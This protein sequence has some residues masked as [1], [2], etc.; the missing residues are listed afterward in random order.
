MQTDFD[1]MLGEDFLA[2]LFKLVAGPRCEEDRASFARKRQRGGAADAF[3]SA[4]YQR[5]FPG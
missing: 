1:F 2:Q 4:C 3:R 5:S